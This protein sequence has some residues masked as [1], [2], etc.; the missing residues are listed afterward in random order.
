[1]TPLGT[2]FAEP[3]TLPTR[4]LLGTVATW[5]A[6]ALCGAQLL[7]QSFLGAM[8]GP[9]LTRLLFMITALGV[10][11]GLALCVVEEKWATAAAGV[12]FLAF[13]YFQMLVFSGNSR[14]PVNPNILF[15]YLPAVS[16]VLFASRSVDMD[17]IFVFLFLASSLYCVAYL[18]LADQILAASQSTDTSG[19]PVLKSDGTREARLYLAAGYPAFALFYALAR[20]DF[21]RRWPW[22][23]GT[24]L[25]LAAMFAAQSRVFLAI[26]VLAVVIRGVGLLNRPMRIMLAIALVLGTVALLFGVLFPGANIYQLFAADASGAARLRAY[27]F[28]SA[29]V[30]DYFL[31]GV[32]LAP[33]RASAAVRMGDPYLYWEDIGPLGIWYTFGMLGLILFIYHTVRCILG[34]RPFVGISE[35]NY[36][37][38]LAVGVVIGLN[39]ITSPGIWNGNTALFLGLVLGSFARTPRQADR[40]TTSAVALV[41]R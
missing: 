8:V 36:S 7:I 14:V 15:T 28:V 5:A 10:F 21:R 4:S 34:P 11:A 13:F 31:F 1:M 6:I 41:S 16:F 32:G 2:A 30:N 27:T 12:F 26:V 19:V 37:A 29:L 17:R 33:D 38:L 20:F 9:E 39:S 18:L 24:L 22:I 3:R 40:A 23:F 25:P 35:P